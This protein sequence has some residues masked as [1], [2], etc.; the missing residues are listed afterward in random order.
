MSRLPKWGKKSQFIFMLFLH[1]NKN[2]FLGMLAWLLLMQRVCQ[3]ENR[4]FGVNFLISEAS[5]DLGRAPQR[6][7]F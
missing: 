2:I 4:G 3:S 7:A 6:N 5:E 1:I